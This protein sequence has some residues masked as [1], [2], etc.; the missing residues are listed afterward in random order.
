MRRTFR[1]IF[2]LTLCGQLFGCVATNTGKI[3]PGEK[4]ELTFT[5]RQQ[6]GQIAASTREADAFAPDAAKSPLFIPK[7]NK[8]PILVTPG[9]KIVQAESERRPEGFE[10]EIIARLTEKLSGASF[11]VPVKLDIASV[12][13]EIRKGEK[14]SISYALVRWRPKE[15]RM[16]P[17]EYLNRFGAQA[18]LGEEYQYDPVLPAGVVTSVSDQEVV[19][20]FKAEAGVRVGT[21]FGPG[22]VREIGDH[23]EIAI[24][25][26]KD[27]LVRLGNL[28]GRISEVGEDSFTVDFSD[29]FAGEKLSCDVLLDPV[30]AQSA[31]A[32]APAGPE[33]LKAQ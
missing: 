21:P 5:C 10:M 22:L 31:S 26:K 25:A 7:T 4:A 19:F 3:K 16:P 23:Y 2:C 29:L 13:A 8:S 33:A 14:Q 1:A 24:E 9:E 32:S 20:T 28:A 17:E 27:A 30:S 11:G 6:N 12:A 15:L 18:K